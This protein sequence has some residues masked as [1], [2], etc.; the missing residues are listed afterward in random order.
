MVKISEAAKQY[1]L[2]KGGILTVS[3]PS[4]VSFCCGQAAL[5]PEISFG[6]P[7]EEAEFLCLWFDG[8]TVFFA[9]ELEKM[10]GLEVDIVRFWGLRKL[11][12]KGWKPV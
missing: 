4:S 6:C 7:R 1:I 12:L 8:V 3:K 2:E 10:E 9:R 11:A 5:E